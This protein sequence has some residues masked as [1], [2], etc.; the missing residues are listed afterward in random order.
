MDWV[1]LWAIHSNHATL[2]IEAQMKRPFLTTG[3]ED[4]GVR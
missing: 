1:A 3:E 2:G 4:T